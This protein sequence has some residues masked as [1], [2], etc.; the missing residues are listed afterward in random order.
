MN[1]IAARVSIRHEE[2][3]GSNI[4]N[5][6]EYQRCHGSLP[7]A[8]RN[9]ENCKLEMLQPPYRGVQINPGSWVLARAPRLGSGP[10]FKTINIGNPPLDREWR[11]LAA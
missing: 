1:A 7:Q 8:S 6:D 11:P 2:A 3:I 5:R 10:T 4:R 9:I